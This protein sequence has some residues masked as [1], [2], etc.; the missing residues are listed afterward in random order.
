MLSAKQRRDSSC[1]G[2]GNERSMQL[3]PRGSGRSCS[4][5]HQTPSKIAGVA[6]VANGRFVRLSNESVGNGQQYR[7]ALSKRRKLEIG[8]LN[9]ITAN[10]IRIRFSLAV[11]ALSLASQ[12]RTA[13]AQSLAEKPA[14]T[15]SQTEAGS[16]AAEE[17]GE[18]ELPWDYSPYRVLVVVA[19]RDPRFSAETLG[20]PVLDYLDRDFNALW[21][22]TVKNAPPPVATAAF[23]S[24]GELTFERI[25]ASDPVIA[26]KRDHEDAV[27]IQSVKSLP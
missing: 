6:V 22:T 5:F 18:Q 24:M 17:A 14:S 27:R 19:S 20:G 13:V 8:I 11:I 15:S 3:A 2:R 23:R 25:A 16:S 21:R 26:V 10:S 7:L 12:G 9:L 4:S 1:T